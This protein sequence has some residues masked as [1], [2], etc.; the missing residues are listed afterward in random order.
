MFG[1]EPE[2]RRAM[3]RGTRRL[4]LLNVPSPVK[5]IQQSLSNEAKLVLTRNP[6]GGVAALLEDCIACAADKLLADCGGPAWDADGFAKRRDRLHAELG[7]TVLGVVGQVQRVLTEANEVE[8]RLADTSGPG[9]EPALADVRE[10]FAGLVYPGFVTATGAARLPD[11]VR[12]LRAIDRRLAKLA[13]NPAR[14]REWMAQ[15]HHVAREYRELRDELP[16]EDPAADGLARIRWMIEELR[17][18]YFA[19]ALGTPYP[20]S[21]KRIFRAM[22]QLTG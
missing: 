19:Q 11:L 10:Q 4:L 22:D 18:S 2:A 15:V 3:W 6:H 21:D 12:Y 17:V 20:V 8:H 13:E 14:D 16:P 5:L 7:E 1:T 9:L